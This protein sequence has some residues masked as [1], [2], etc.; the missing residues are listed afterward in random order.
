MA[1]MQQQ[2]FFYVLFFFFFHFGKESEVDK[3]RS[4]SV[5]RVRT[6]YQQL[7]K[8]YLENKIYS[9]LYIS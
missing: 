3:S 6:S 4:P 8:F 5:S 1:Y 2:I 9:T 7:H